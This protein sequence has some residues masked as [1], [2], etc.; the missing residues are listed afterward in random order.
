MKKSIIVSLASL[1]MITGCSSQST[2]ITG[3]KADS[4]YEETLDTELRAD[5]VNSETNSL[6]GYGSSDEMVDT[7]GVTADSYYEEDTDNTGIDEVN[8]KLTPLESYRLD[9][10][11]INKDDLYNLYV[12]IN[13]FNE[14]V[15]QDVSYLNQ[16][17]D[18][19]SDIYGGEINVSRHLDSIET[20][21][22]NLDKIDKF[23]GRLDKTDAGFKLAKD[24]WKPLS[25]EFK[26]FYGK[27]K[28]GIRVGDNLDSDR[29]IELHKDFTIEIRR[30][31]A[32]MDE[33]INAEI[34]P[35]DQSL[36]DSLDKLLRRATFKDNVYIYLNDEYSEYCTV[37]FNTWYGH[38]NSMIDTG[39][40]EATFMLMQYL[41]AEQIEDGLYSIPMNSSEFNSVI[42]EV[43]KYIPNI[44]VTDNILK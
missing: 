43:I 33:S 1:M 32:K 4:Y 24:L 19:G 30:Y 25:K 41:K 5:E 39:Y 7:T 15:S 27:V 11:G 26:S 8:N 23:I 36:V 31:Y 18:R 38:E 44:S 2:D 9:S 10:L 28:D 13:Y 16:Y 6:V 29:Y 3:V 35:Y 40:D 22:N 34:N 20:T 37:Y 21:Y 14:T 17:A 42:E 12:V